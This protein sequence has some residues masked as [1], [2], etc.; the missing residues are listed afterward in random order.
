MDLEPATEDT[1]AEDWG[2]FSGG[3]PIFGVLHEYSP[4]DVE[5][6]VSRDEN[7][8]KTGL[9]TWWSD[10]ET[11][12]VVSLHATPQGCGTGARLMDAAESELKG[13]GV[14]RVVLA[15][16]NDNVRAL[17][18]Y[19]RR[20]YRLVGVRLDEMARIRQTKPDVPRVGQDGVPLRDMWEL[21]KEL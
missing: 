12:E 8:A 1:I 17:S 6:L 13:S 5:G 20:G 3:P 14:T 10:G 15:T 19:Q 21:E 2:E 9:V 7:G 18:F 16:T 4:S 11:A